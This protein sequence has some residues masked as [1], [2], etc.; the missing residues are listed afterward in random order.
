MRIARLASTLLLVLAC[1]P[2]ALAQ[3]SCAD[4]DDLCTGDPCTITNVEVQSPCIVDFGARAVVIAGKLD[5]PDD[6]TL[7]FTAATI[8]VQGAI[9]GRHVGNGTGN[10]A[11]ITLIASTGD[12]DVRN[13]IDVS[14]T[15]STGTIEI[16]AAGDILVKDHLNAKPAGSNITAVGGTIQLSAQGAITTDPTAVIDAQGGGGSI[17]IAGASGV[18]VRGRVRAEGNANGTIQVTSSAGVVTI[19]KD[20]RVDRPDVP[21]GTVEVSGEG[22]VRVNDLIRA[23]SEDAIGGTVTLTSGSGSVEIRAR[24]AVRGI[25]GGSLTIASPLATFES[26]VHLDALATRDNGGSITITAATINVR[27]NLDVRGKDGSGGTVELT[28]TSAVNL[29]GGDARADGEVGGSITL[30]GDAASGDVVLLTS[31]Q[32]RATGRGAG[33][34]L[35]VSAPAG[36]VSGRANVDI[37]SRDG[38]GGLAFVDGVSVSIGPSARIDVGSDF[39][40]EMRFA[41]SGTGL[42]LLDGI[43]DARRGGVIEGISNGDLTVRRTFR[44]APGGCIGLS[45]ASPPDT[46]GATF[47]TPVTPSCP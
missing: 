14:G 3:V 38:F 40:G 28:A 39:G 47:D 44:A 31:S 22:G 37:G 12:V 10:G 35:V 33:G 25:S 8:R 7:S 13:E 24:P 21:G 41:Q 4:P 20:L 34:L 46:S 15:A 23:A 27:R 30:R 36:T 45:A 29:T 17:V 6:G 26:A 18:T 11:S 43:F 19:D 16:D 1:V 42:M 9:D 5:V 32:L 2:R